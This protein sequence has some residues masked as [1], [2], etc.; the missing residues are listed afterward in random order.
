MNDKN[1]H[2]N[3]EKEF[4]ENKSMRKTG[5]RSPKNGKTPGKRGKALKIILAV[6]CVIIV[7]IFAVFTYFKRIYK[8]RHQNEDGINS[9]I[10]TEII[11]AETGEKISM[12]DG[13]YTFLATG[14][15]K[16]ESLTDVIMVASYN[17]SEKK[18]AI[19]SIPRDT[20]VKV[21][22]K[23]ILDDSGAISKDNFT[24]GY[25]IKIN[26]A[27]AK[28]RSFAG[29]ELEQ[30]A[31]NAK[32]KSDAEIKK[33]CSDSFL[34]IDAKT[35]KA[36][37]NETDKTK[38]KQMYEDIRKKFGI[39][40][41]G[42]LIYYN[43]GVPVDFY[44]QVN[45]SGFRG[46]VD[47][48]G[49]VDV[50]IQ[51]DMNYDDPLQDLHIHLKKGSQHLDGNKAEQFVRFRKG[52]V[53]ADLARIDAQ[54]IF[55]TAFIKKLLSFS[56]VTKIGSVAEEIQKNLTTNL[57][58]SDAVYFATNALELDLANITMITLPGASQYMD[59]ASYY[60][61]NKAAVLE[62]VNNY[63]NKYSKPLA[64]S[65]LCLAEISDKAPQGT[66][67][68]TADDISNEEP[69][70]AFVKSGSGSH[71]S[72]SQT[73]TPKPAPEPAAPEPAAPET[74]VSEN[75]PSENTEAPENSGENKS[76]NG[77]GTV[78]PS[79][80]TDDGTN[81]GENSGETGNTDGNGSENSENV[82]ENQGENTPSESGNNTAENESSNFVIIPETNTVN[83]E[84]EA[85]TDIL[86]EK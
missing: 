55:M 40:Y 61:A 19:M 4:L 41:L 21:N 31:K 74:P 14:C 47:A 5:H 69:H 22:S 37:M 33:L 77:E 51:Q 23:L 57:T 50:V 81:S 28:G 54:K 80:T 67:I 10:P 79:E 64:E 7:L 1:F 66:G 52:Y 11:D 82:S 6:L 24:G 65:N 45:V 15:D 62:T 59:G 49:G 78:Q 17:M 13:T 48:V 12:H 46:V 44:A 85:N 63:L 8:P 20:Y 36:Y 76:E 73:S 29:D 70:I 58:V 30:L 72:S 71:S 9:G 84:S 83:N 38:K 27:Y 39:K 35:L 18:V 42:T 26:A 32:D 16:S 56:T 86:P 53:S 75:K 43:F 60:S 25:G 34:S 68:M 3:S 2:E